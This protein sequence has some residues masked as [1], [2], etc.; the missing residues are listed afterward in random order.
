MASHFSS[1]HRPTSLLPDIQNLLNQSKEEEYIE[2]DKSKIQLIDEK[3]NN[4]NKD[5]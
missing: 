3:K 2:E 4:I 5:N 1:E